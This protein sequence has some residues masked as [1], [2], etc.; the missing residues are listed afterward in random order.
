MKQKK[1]VLKA[2]LSTEADIKLGTQ[3]F[4]PPRPKTISIREPTPIHTNHNMQHTR[5]TQYTEY[6]QPSQKGSVGHMTP[7]PDPKSMRVVPLCLLLIEY[8]P[9]KTKLRLK[10]SDVSQR[11]LVC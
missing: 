3:P 9:N 4:L 10:F 6:T 11:S 7:K 5:V 2:Q 1:Y 8:S